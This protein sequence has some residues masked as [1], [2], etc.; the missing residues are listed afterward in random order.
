MLAVA[1]G[2]TLHSLHEKEGE[3]EEEEKAGNQSG[4]SQGNLQRGR[5]GQ[6]PFTSTPFQDQREE[7]GE[8][9]GERRG[10]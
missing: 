6:F 2:D 5:R 8:R 9:E 7:N 3:E 4:R 10:I 1:S